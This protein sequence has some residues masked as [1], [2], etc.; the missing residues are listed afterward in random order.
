[1][2]TRRSFS[3]NR[4][5][6]HLRM[7][8]AVTLV[9][10][11][12]ALAFVA[13]KPL[14][15]LW[16]KA[17]SKAGIDKLRQ[18][19]AALFRNKLTIPG[20]AREGGP[21]AAAEEEYAQRAYPA[22]YVPFELTRNAHAA[23]TNVLSRALGPASATRRLIPK[24]VS[25]FIKRSMAATHGLILPR[26]LT[27]RLGPALIALALSGLAA[28]KRPPHTAVPPLMDGRSPQL[29]STQTIQI[30]FTLAP[31]AR[32]AVSAPSQVAAL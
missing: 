2:K 26:T 22:A 1:M 10:A 17:E 19:R 29:L 5:A 3:R 9:S 18:D 24:P 11:A 7:A 25:E 23:W 31:L 6:S 27:S 28:F 4:L 21:T 8:S 12:A 14:G 30:R 13:V 15:P 20:P 16:A 32:C